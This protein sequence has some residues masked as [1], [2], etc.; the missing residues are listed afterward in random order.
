MKIVEEIKENWK[1]ILLETGVALV[2]GIIGYAIG[3]NNNKGIIKKNHYNNNYKH[4]KYY[5]R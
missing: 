5:K 1:R 2:F 3:K 4:E